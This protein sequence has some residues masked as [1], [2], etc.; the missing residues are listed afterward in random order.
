MKHSHA[1]PYLGAILS[2]VIM[3][4]S[5]LFTKIALGAADPITLTAHRFSIAFFVLVLAIALKVIKLTI[6]ARNIKDILPVIVFYPVFFLTQAYGMMSLSSSEAAIIQAMTPIITMI[7]ASVFLRENITRLQSFFLML[8]VFGVVYIIIGKGIRF[9]LDEI[10]GMFLVLVA[11]FTGS[12]YNV[13][14]RKKS[15]SLTICDLTFVM[16]T[17][18]FIFFNVLALVQSVRTGSS[19]REYFSVLQD[20]AVLISILF[21]ACFASLG[22]AILGIKVL[23]K[24]EASKATVF[25]NL[26]T[27]ISIVAGVLF[28]HETIEPYHIVGSA[29]IIVGILGTNRSPHKEQ[30]DVSRP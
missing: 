28:L 2:S 25:T 23:A 6:T 7:L 5:F 19:I 1:A 9:Q 26:G 15:Q 12:C 10:F 4:L 27:V 3:G 8:S 22:N 29:L 30:R 11:T 24:L 13:T 18:S 21:L 14:M 16:F 20:P 17:F